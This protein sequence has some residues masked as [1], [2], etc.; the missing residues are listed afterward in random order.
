MEIPS[1]K[2]INRRLD[3]I[4]IVL[5]IFGGLVLA[6]IAW[7][8][9]ANAVSKAHG[10]LPWAKFTVAAIMT[11]LLYGM[12]GYLSGVFGFKY[13]IIFLCHA[14]AGYL[15]A[16][17]SAHLSYDWYGAILKLAGSNLNLTSDYVFDITAKTRFTITAVILIVIAAIMSFFYESLVNQ[18]YMRLSAMSVGS[19]LI[20]FS[21]FFIA[22][23]FIVDNFNNA[24]FRQPL[25]RTEYY[26]DRARAIQS[27]EIANDP[28]YASWERTF[29]NL[30]VDLSLPHRLFTASYEPQWDTAHIWVIFGQTK[31]DCLVVAEQPFTCNLMP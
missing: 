11:V 18:I 12:A 20:T 16:W 5:G 30:D 23:G 24:T 7:G 2:I 19:A 1:D 6:I 25:I 9:D 31:Y 27:G 4:R 17:I 15:T 26:L 8:L 21:V 3:W 28:K 22:S 13:Y 29:L 14:V 10:T